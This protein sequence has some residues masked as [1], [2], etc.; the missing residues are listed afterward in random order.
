MVALGHAWI[1]TFAPARGWCHWAKIPSFFQG[2][3]VDWQG[4]CGLG[5]NQLRPT[6]ETH[7]SPVACVLYCP[8][9]KC[10]SRGEP[11]GQ[12]AQERLGKGCRVP[13][14][15]SSPAAVCVW[16]ST[17]CLD[18]RRQQEKEEGVRM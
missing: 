16:V 12:G 11:S 6:G 3:G 4:C 8:D 14:N 9:I 15:S 7:D 10:P 18:V 5:I 1:Y 17:A 2:F 13:G